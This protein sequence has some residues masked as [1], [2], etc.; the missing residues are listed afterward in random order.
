MVKDMVGH[1]TTLMEGTT[2]EQHCQQTNK[3]T[4]TSSGKK[5]KGQKRKESR[6]H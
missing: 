1:K 3:A 2:L 6:H 5:E 4:R